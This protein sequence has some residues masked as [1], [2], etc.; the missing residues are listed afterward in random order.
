M[1]SEG[2][3][4]DRL[5]DVIKELQAIV[6]SIAN[7]VEKIESIGSGGGSGGG[8]A[9][10]E[11]YEPNKE[12]KRNVL[13]VDTATEIVY[14]VLGE[15]TSVSVKE[16]CAEGHLMLVGFE[17]Q[18]VTFSHKPTQKEINALPDNVLVAIYS[19]SDTPYVPEETGE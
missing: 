19:P 18:I 11:D 4:F 5:T 17:S 16:D 10:I 9:T 3:E 2:R 15:Y 13:V 1:A 6:N 14:R 7:K 8:S 12:Y